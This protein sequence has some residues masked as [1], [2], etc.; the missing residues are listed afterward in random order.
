MRIGINLFP[1]TIDGFVDEVR[2]AAEVGFASAWSSHTFGPDAFVALAAAAREVTDIS[3]VTAVVP[4]HTRHPM[5]MAQQALSVQSASHGRFTLGIGVSHQMVIEG[6]LGLDFARPASH[7]AQYLEVLAPLLRTGSAD[8]TGAS[9][10]YHGTLEV[11]DG[12]PVPLL[13][14][15]MG[16]RMLELAGSV[17]DGTILTFTGPR[18]VADYIIPTMAAAATRASRPTPEVRMAVPVSITSEVDAARARAA[19][20]MA[21]YGE[22]PSYKAMIERE[23]VAGPADL[24]YI[25]D[26]DQVVADVLRLEDCGANEVAIVPFGSPDDIQRT[27]NT[28][29]EVARGA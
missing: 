20:E 5:A 3:L 28:L 24:A 16:P 14:A 19:E 18:T 23:G 11:A 2:Q 10:S 13:L 8:H 7:T 12:A 26:E 29:G 6:M 21:F 27:I 22:L 25:G 15:A 1:R 9:F 4:T 17:C